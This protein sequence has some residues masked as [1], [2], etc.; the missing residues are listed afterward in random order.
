MT[1][2]VIAILRCG[3]RPRQSLSRIG[4]LPRRRGALRPTTLAAEASTGRVDVVAVRTDGTRCATVA[5]A[6]AAAR[7]RTMPRWTSTFV[8]S[9]P[10]R[11]RR[12]DRRRPRAPRTRHARARDGDPDR[13][14]VDLGDRVDRGRRGPRQRRRRSR[15][16]DP[17]L[18]A[19]ERA[20]RLLPRLVDDDGDGTTGRRGLDEERAVGFRVRDDAGDLRVFPRDAR[21]EAP[22]RWRDRSGVLGEQPAGLELR[23]EGAFRSAEPDTRRADRGPAHGSTSGRGRPTRWWDAASGAGRSYH[24]ARLEPG[25]AGHDRRPGAALRRPGRPDGC[26]PRPGHGRARGRP[27]GRDGPR[28]G[29][30]GRRPG[31]RPGRGVGQRRDPRVRDRPAERPATIDPGADPLPARRCGRRGPR[32]A[33]V[34]DRARALVRRGACPTAR[35]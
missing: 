6:P 8:P 33:D 2:V 7:S 9:D 30:R 5:E 13:R 16:G 11:R 35:S 10:G 4:T 20:V 34:R 25:D 17:R 24:E 21:I 1:F 27:G 19:P 29:A 14:H 22:D 12:G 26:R 3:V 31:G 15:R 32:R 18:A 28:R 23:T